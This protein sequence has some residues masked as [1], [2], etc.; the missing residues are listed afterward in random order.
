MDPRDFLRDLRLRLIG[1]KSI[2]GESGV[3]RHSR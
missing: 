2:F 3:Q 1:H